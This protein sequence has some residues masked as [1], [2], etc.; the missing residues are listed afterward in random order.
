[1][2]SS[3]SVAQQ[4]EDRQPI[5]VDDDPSPAT[6]HGRT[7]RP[8]AA[9]AILGK[10]SVKIVS[11]FRVQTASVDVLSTRNRAQQPA[12]HFLFSDRRDRRFVLRRKA[13]PPLAG[14]RSPRGFAHSQ[15]LPLDQYRLLTVP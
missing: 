15:T 11:V 8:S 9:S 13:G 6:K 12:R 4:V 1:M 3:L 5:P 7:A 10:R 14:E 2:P